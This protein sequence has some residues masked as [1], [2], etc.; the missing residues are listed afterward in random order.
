MKNEGTN[1]SKARA[2]ITS[3]CNML[4][5][6]QRFAPGF[7]RDLPFSSA[8]CYILL[9]DATKLFCHYVSE[10]YDEPAGKRWS[11][12]L[13]ELLLSHPERCQETLALVEQKEFKEISYLHFVAA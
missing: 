6:A 7:A 12:S 9:Q 2:I 1:L 10:L 4:H 13:P 5:Q 8:D 3:A 11:P